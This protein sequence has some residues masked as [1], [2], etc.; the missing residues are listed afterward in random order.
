[1]TAVLI[2]ASVAIVFVYMIVS[3]IWV[4]RGKP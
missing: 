2:F 3:L 4:Y 1:M